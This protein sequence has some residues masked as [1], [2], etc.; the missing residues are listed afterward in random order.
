M[1]VNSR[2]AFLPTSANVTLFTTCS[3]NKYLLKGCSLITR[4]VI[5]AWIR[6]NIAVS[7]LDLNL[8]WEW[9]NQPRELFHLT[10]NTVRSIHVHRNTAAAL[11]DTTTTLLL[12]SAS[13][14]WKHEKYTNLNTFTV[15]IQLSDV[16]TKCGNCG[17]ILVNGWIDCYIS[18]LAFVSQP[19][20][21]SIPGWSCMQHWLKL[22][23]NH[24]HLK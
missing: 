9:D 22:H 3:H 13:R 19:N 10:K 24:P 20:L 2:F 4:H 16:N 17:Q 14:R 7:F 5:N 11:D 1:F 15:A 8:A 18:E 12:T 23:I 6:R 21:G